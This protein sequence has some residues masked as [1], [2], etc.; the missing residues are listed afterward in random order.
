MAK[1]QAKK[2]QE[3]EILEPEVLGPDD[4]M[5][6]GD[7]PSTELPPSADGRTDTTAVVPVTALQQYVAIPTYRRK[8]NSGFLRNIARRAAVKRP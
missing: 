5:P 8:K 6:Q 4:A 3:E 1:R 2:Q 7:T